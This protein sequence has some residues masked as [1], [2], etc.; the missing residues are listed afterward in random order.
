MT[1]QQVLAG[2]AAAGVIATGGTLT[3]DQMINPY[4]PIDTD[5]G[6]VLEITAS[7]TIPDAG[8]ETAVLSTDSPTLTL[9]KWDGQVQMGITYEGLPDQTTGARPFLSKD[10]DWSDAQQSMQVVPLDASSTFEDGGYE[11][12]VTLNSEPASNVF[13]FA[14]SGADDLDFFYQAP[15]W[16]EAGLEAPTEDCTDTDCSTPEGT[17]HRPDNVVGSYAVYYK[18]HAN[19]IDGQTNYATGKAYQIFR[20][21]VT[22]AVGSTT[23]ATLSYDDAGT[24]T[25]TV[26]QD[27]LDGA[28]YPVTVDPT[29]GYSAIGGTSGSWS[30]NFALRS[31]K[32]YAGV[33]GTLTSLSIYG[34]KSSGTLNLQEG[35]YIASTKQDSSVA[36]TVN[37]TPQWLT[38]NAVTGVTTA[39]ASNYF[40]YFNTDTTGFVPVYDTTGSGFSRYVAQAYG[41]WPSSMTDANNNVNNQELSMYATY[42][43]AGIPALVQH[44]LKK[45]TASGTTCP[46]TIISSQAGS[47]LTIA[48]YNRNS[49]TVTGVTDN[50][51]ADGWTHV[52]NGAGSDG[53]GVNTADTWY[54][55]APTAGV[56]TITVQYSGSAGTDARTCEAWE[57]AGFTNPVF[58]TGGATL[59]ATGVGTSDNGPSLTTTGSTGFSWAVTESSGSTS[60]FPKS[61]NEYTAGGDLSGDF[62]AGFAS[63]IYASSGTHQPVAL[64]GSS[65]ATFTMSAGAIMNSSGGGGA[66]TY[67]ANN[68][69]ATF[70]Q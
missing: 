51:G 12:N 31:A 67:N 39:A 25:V 53:S 4:T 27:F 60:A 11:I 38:G 45:Q 1:M 62:I 14:I 68:W 6:Q 20:P 55:L 13:N 47:V 36:V 65:G 8:T 69:Q 61:G 7:S 23:W 3:A 49:R 44:V 33:N 57:V 21:Q 2:V 18:D 43:A 42:T 32:T 17:S 16:Q 52:T 34:S 46:V 15:L 59:N 66:S 22:D 64:D 70:D 40:I 24:L 26:P 35:L 63:L 58:D 30:A 19:H 10:V 56:K 50:N 29:F 37:T 9:S 28:T 48:A 54:T 41:T 5:Q